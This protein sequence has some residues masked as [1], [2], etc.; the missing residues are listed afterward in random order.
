MADLL[1]VLAIDGGGIRGMSSR[2][3][4][5]ARSRTRTKTSICKLFDLIAGTSTGGI[6][7]L[8]LVK[9]SAQDEELPEYK[10]AD[11]AELYEKE[12]RRIFDRSLWHR[13]VALD[14]LIDEKYDAAG[15][16]DGAP[17]LLWRY[18][19]E[20]GGHG[21]ACHELRAR[22]Q[23]AL[24]LCAPQGPRGTDLRFPDALR[25]PRHLGCPDLLRARGVEGNQ[26][27][28]GTR[29]RRRV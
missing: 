6:L 29:R 8:G 7:A 9:P 16:E 24:V 11:L 21:D 20:Q 25:R 23:A 5:S 15:L 10:A 26:A 18:P 17:G 1:K 27:A 22:D 3:R 4:S 28:R 14:N 19:A 2:P 12:G 13:I